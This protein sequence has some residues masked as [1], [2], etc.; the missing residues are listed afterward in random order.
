MSSYMSPLTPH[1]SPLTPHPSLLTPH[2]SLLPPPSS[3]LTSF[4]SAFLPSSFL[5]LSSI[6]FSLLAVS[7]GRALPNMELRASGLSDPAGLERGW[8]ECALIFT[9]TNHTRH[10]SLITPHT[11]KENVVIHVTPHSLNSLYTIVP[12]GIFPLNYDNRAFRHSVY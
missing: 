6:S 7:T 8:G 4:S 1:P 5:S 10:P 2:S 9:I 12:K 3:L 11:H